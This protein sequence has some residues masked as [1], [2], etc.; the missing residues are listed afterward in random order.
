MPEGSLLISVLRSGKGFVPSA[1]TVLEEIGIITA[2]NR[3]RRMLLERL[4]VAEHGEIDAASRLAASRGADGRQPRSARIA[5]RLRVRV[6]G[7]RLLADRE[8]DARPVEDRSARRRQAAAA[9]CR[10]P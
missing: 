8:L 4:E 6:N 5:D 7:R 10:N 1:D 3:A 9:T 2:M